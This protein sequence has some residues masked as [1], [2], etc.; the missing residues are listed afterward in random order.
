MSRL[1]AGADGVRHAANSLPPK[2]HRRRLQRPSVNLTGVERV[3]RMLIGVAGIVLGIA[4]L[5]P[6]GATL[7]VIL[8]V[9]LVLA[10]VDLLVTGALGHCPL[11]HK[12]GYA[13]PSLRDPE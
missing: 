6:P 9:L 4:L 7:A 13:P 2:T 10:G 5:M 11:Y 3:G 12:L 1:A 8:E